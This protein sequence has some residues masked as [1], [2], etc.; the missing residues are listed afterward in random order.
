[1]SYLADTNLI[2]RL[3]VRDD[4]EQFKATV[5][6]LSSFEQNGE[7]CHVPDVIWIEACWVLEK[8]YKLNRKAISE[9]LIDLLHTDTFMPM[10][11]HIHEMLS[12]YGDTTIDATDAYL[13]ALARSLNHMV[14][15]W[16]HRD[17]RRL[18]CEW[19]TPSQVNYS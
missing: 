5:Q 17:F 15:T 9:A 16:N 12:I 6:A 11:G 2:V 13:S 8:V 14:L 19:L 7:V 3:L 4:E 18:E 10:S 1:M